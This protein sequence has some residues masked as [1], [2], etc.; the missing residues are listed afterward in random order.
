[1]FIL[2]LIGVFIMIYCSI[3]ILTAI[4]L[5]RANLLVGKILLGLFFLAMSVILMML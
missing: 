1:M 5:T 2:P 4:K 3:S